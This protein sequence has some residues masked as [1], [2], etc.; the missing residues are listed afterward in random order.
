MRE[1]V[2]YFRAMGYP[3]LRASDY[4]RF[5]SFLHAMNALQD[6]DLLDPDKLDRA[7]IECE[8]FHAFLSELLERVGQREE[9]QGIAFDK[10]AAA[11]TLRLY[12][13]E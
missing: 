9:L 4:P 7:I 12:L 6:A 3:L 1:F 13:R 10:R 5:A 11:M 8:A 2:A